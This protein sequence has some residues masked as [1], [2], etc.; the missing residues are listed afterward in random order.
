MNE[1]LARLPVGAFVLDLGCC[2][3]SFPD[4]ATAATAV[5]VDLEARDTGGGERWVS[6]CG[7][8]GCFHRD[9]PPVS[10]VGRRAGTRGRACEC[11]YFGG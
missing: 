11:V 8:A 2:A 3:G 6:V 1:I 9:G 7:R 10:L 4:S 5:R